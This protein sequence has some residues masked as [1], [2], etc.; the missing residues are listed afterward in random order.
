MSFGNDLDGVSTLMDIGTDL[1][2]TGM[3]ETPLGAGVSSLFH[4]GMGVYDVATGDDAG[5]V[6]E[7]TEST[8]A[9][10]GAIPGIGPLISAGDMIG[11]A[12]ASG[13]EQE[14]LSGMAG[15]A[16][17]GMIAGDGPAQPVSNAGQTGA[18]IGAEAGGTL[19]PFAGAVG[20]AALGRAAG[21]AIGSLF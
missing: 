3:K 4:A 20:G 11:G 5:A 7:A 18:M 6:K 2:L 21:D 10:L 17:G 13:G 8:A 19:I 9:G 16:L 15:E 14:T 12:I 1:G